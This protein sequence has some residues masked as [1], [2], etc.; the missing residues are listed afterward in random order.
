M[1]FLNTLETAGIDLKRTGKPGEYI[2]VC[3]Q[4][5]K[6]KLAINVDKEF[7]QCWYCGEGGKSRYSLA[8]WLG[9]KLAAN[10][11]QN[12]SS[13]RHK[14]VEAKDLQKK[15]IRDTNSILPHEFCSLT[16]GEIGG[17]IRQ[18]ARAYLHGRG[19]TDKDICQ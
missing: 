8:K 10:Q 19:L 4:C 3:P 2:A 15:P 12:F 14:Y 7:W 6:Q 18:R 11:V 5:S 9:I 16:N 17:I 1:S 13:L